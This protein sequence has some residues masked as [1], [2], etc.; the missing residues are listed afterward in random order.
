LL[1]R[2]FRLFKEFTIERLSRV[3]LFVGKNNS[4]KSCLLEALEVYVHQANPLVLRDLVIARKEDWEYLSSQRETKF[5]SIEEHP[6]RYLFYGYHFPKPGSSGIEIGPATN[7]AD[8]V[9]IRLCKD[10]G[11]NLSSMNQKIE[12]EL[13]AAQECFQINLF[14]D[15][16]FMRDPIHSSVPFSKPSPYK[17]NLQKIPAQSL[18]DELAA[19][20]WDIINLT[21]FE[22]EV[23]SCLQM[24]EPRVKGVAFVGDSYGERQ[25]IPIVRLKDSAER[26]PLKSMGDGMMRLFHISLSLVNARDGFLLIDEFENGIHWTVQPKLWEMLFRVAEKLNVQVFATTHSRDCVRGF[27]EVWSKQEDM[28]SFHRLD[29]DP[30]MGVRS[31]SYTCEILSDALETGVEVR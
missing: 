6:F 22:N 9:H 18:S 1:I 17:Y 13:E 31:T 30:E 2:N 7:E 23:I 25:R 20:L 12:L 14:D 4:G 26:I 28:G 19:T 16:D 8:R 10:Q 5:V 3:N 24:I 27:Y 21:D 29:P 15:P 11:N